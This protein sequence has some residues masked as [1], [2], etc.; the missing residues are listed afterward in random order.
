ML[1]L[2]LAT[3]PEPRVIGTGLDPSWRYALHRAAL[4]GMTFGRDIVFSY[5][6]MGYL[7][8]MV[9]LGDTFVAV[10]RFQ[11]LV[12]CL[13]L[14]LLLIEIRARPERGQRWM[15]A[16][17]GL[18][19]YVMN[20][21]E[22]DYV[23]LWSF[24]LLVTSRRLASPERARRW[25]LPLGM[26]AG[27][28]LTTKFTLGICSLAAL[29][30]VLVAGAV[31]AL[32]RRQGRWA[33]CAALVGELCQR[34]FDHRID[35][36]IRPQRF[37][38]CR[39]DRGGILECVIIRR[40]LHVLDAANVESV[41]GRH[42]GPAGVH[43]P[44]HLSHFAGPHRT[45]PRRIPAGLMRRNARLQQVVDDLVLVAEMVT[46]LAWIDFLHPLPRQVIHRDSA[47]LPDHG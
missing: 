31:R 41:A 44:Q 43:D 12:H 26:A 23:F 18:F 11:L 38:R 35:G 14:G 4:E 46:E 1:Y 6:P 37:R 17:G 3:I 28:A 2:F 15:L 24:L 19:P 20:R 39:G 32:Y 7:T 29:L 40:A 30:L 25:A 45:R 8:T 36:C 9:A 5:G 22:T 16:A 33:A 13:F 47:A 27:F 21:C 42:V 34:G 10:Q